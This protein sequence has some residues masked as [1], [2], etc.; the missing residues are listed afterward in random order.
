MAKRQRGS[1]TIRKRGKALYLRYRPPGQARQIEEVFPRREGET[2]K[3]CRARAEAELE[4]LTYGLKAG[5]LNAPTRRTVEELAQEYLDSIHST[6][7]PRTYETCER[8]LRL[9]VVSTL[10]NM[11]VDQLTPDAIRRFQQSLLNRQVRQDGTTMAVSTAR[12]AMGTFRDM[13]KHALDGPVARTYWG[14]SFDPWPQRRLKWPDAREK[15]APRTYEPYSIKE[16]RQYLTATPDRLRPHVLAIVCLMLRDGEFRGMRWADLDEERGVYFVRQQQS[17]VHGMATT[18][19]ESSTAEV[20]VAGVLLDALM[21][22][23]KH[24]VEMRLKK[25]DKWQDHDLI[26]TTSKG[27]ALPHWQMSQRWNPEIAKAAGVCYISLH[28]L[29][30]TGSTIL[31]TELGSRR[32]TVQAA[33]RHKRR[34]VTDVYVAYDV[35]KL[36]PHF[37][38][39]AVALMDGLPST[40][41]QSEVILA[42]SG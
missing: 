14:I 10:S 13:L 29:R 21:D 2:M 41:P 8:H 31:E 25:G 3:E 19:T 12:A 39:L 24:Q 17:R 11:R 7:K 40:C 6:V 9:Y 1:G 42:A 28:T 16:M 38:G 26:F 36:R 18:K 27:T 33:L 5:T 23:K 4:R 35:E 15:P 34:G 37:E 30:K 22:H 32:E 20:P